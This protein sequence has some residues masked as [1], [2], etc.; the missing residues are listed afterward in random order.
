MTGVLLGEICRHRNKETH[1]EEGHMMMEAE[2]GVMR[3]QAEEHQRLP[4]PT[5]S[6]ERDTEQAL[7][8]VSSSNQPRQR[9]DLGL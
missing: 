5:R 3:L 4:T 7:P 2:I 8:R 1:R 9:S 6:R